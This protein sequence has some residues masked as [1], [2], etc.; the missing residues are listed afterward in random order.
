MAR[1]LDI[2][3]ITTAMATAAYVD[4]FID[5]RI[6][7]QKNRKRNRRALFLVMLFAGAFAG[8]FAYKRLGS[9]FTLL[10]SAVGKLVV[11]GAFFFNRPMKMERVEGC[12]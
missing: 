4:L 5:P 1:S 6:L 11:L 12:V 9:A 8:A 10:M 7:R 3:E 2:T